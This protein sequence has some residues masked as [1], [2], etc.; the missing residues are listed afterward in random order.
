M[1]IIHLNGAKMIDKAA[2]HTYLKRRL[3]LPSYYGDNL[4][5][6]W[7]CLMSDFSGKKIV[8][9]E[10]QTIMN[11]LGSYGESIISLFRKV[12]EE[13]VSIQVSFKD[14]WLYKGVIR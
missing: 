12:A 14:K 5:A 2:T 10:P 8:I 3:A 4:D 13:N 11:N 1:K 7:D 6:L 9:H